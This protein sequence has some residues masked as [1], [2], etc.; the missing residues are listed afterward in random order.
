MVFLIYFD[1][2]FDVVLHLSYH[3]HGYP[4]KKDKSLCHVVTL[5]YFVYHFV[6]SISDKI[7]RER[8][9]PCYYDIRPL[10]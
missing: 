4:T 10:D 8:N 5:F 2:L 6:F 9:P 1:F 7:G 3:R